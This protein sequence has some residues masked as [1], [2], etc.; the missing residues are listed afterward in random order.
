MKSQIR[1]R[2]KARVCNLQLQIHC[3]YLFKF[4]EI[5]HENVLEKACQNIMVPKLTIKWKL[6]FFKSELGGLEDNSHVMMTYPE[7][8]LSPSKWDKAIYKSHYSH[9]LSVIALSQSELL[10]I[11]SLSQ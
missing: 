5:S 11:W 6:F 10:W 2:G 1:V 8:L 7:G 9:S 4:M 3:P